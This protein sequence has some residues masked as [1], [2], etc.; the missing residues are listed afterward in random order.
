MPTMPALS[1][2]HRAR[3][4]AFTLVELLVVIAII[5]VLIGLLLP[6]LSGISKA[7]KKNATQNMMNSFT[8]A[9]A[10]FSNDNGSRMPG[11]FSPFEMGGEDNLVAGMSA[12]EN[13]LLELS[14]TDVIVGRYEDYSSDINENA[15]II[16]IAPF[17]NTDPNAVVVNTKLIGANGSYF[18]PDTNYL[19]VLKTSENQQVVGNGLGQELMP[20]LVDAFGN[21]MLAW[22]QDTSSRGSIDPNNN[23]PDGFR[24]F[25]TATSDGGG[26]DDGPAW[27]YLASNDCFIGDD[28]N[29]I[30]LGGI[31][32]NAF[33]ALSTQRLSGGSGSATISS[34]DRIR[35]LVALL[36]SPS[37]YALPSGESLD[38]IEPHDILPSRPRGRML[39]QSGGVDGYFL[40]TRDQGWG[41][42]AFT[43]GSEYHLGFGFN[44]KNDNG[45][46]QGDDGQFI[47][48]DI[49]DEFD[50]II[51]S[52]N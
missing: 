28:A 39:I 17:T 38:M 23:D 9:V 20:D 31:N 43:E 45:R 48:F 4:R 24:Q 2:T 7:G 16:S 46:H 40:G 8:N 10:S 25:A 13:I 51:Q 26:A 3:S 30:G 44:F 1:H 36:A 35:T 6:A 21:P 15:G 50:D 47:T 41:A 12:M 14:G 34:D 29:N 52:V 42:N 5:A 11:Y 33:S 27:F 32:Q 22:V 37:Y 18:A 49:I 19:K